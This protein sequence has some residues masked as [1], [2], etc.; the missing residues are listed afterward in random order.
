[1]VARAALGRA[2]AHFVSA[3]VMEFVRYCAPVAPEV[4]YAVGCVLDKQSLVIKHTKSG[5]QLIKRLCL[6]V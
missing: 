2:V 4:R 3:L 6:I 5:F 1:L